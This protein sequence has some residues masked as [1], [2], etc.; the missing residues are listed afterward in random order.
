MVTWLFETKIE[1][2]ARIVSSK[3][4][5][6]FSWAI[7]R[8]EAYLPQSI[9]IT[10]TI[11]NSIETSYVSKHDKVRARSKYVHDF[12]RFP[13]FDVFLL[14]LLVCA[15]MKLSDLS[16]VYHPP[17]ISDEALG[18]L[19][20]NFQ[21]VYI[22]IVCI[23]FGYSFPLATP[24]FSGF[25]ACWTSDT[26]LA[27]MYNFFLGKRFLYLKSSTQQYLTLNSDV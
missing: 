3:R 25:W 14:R 8:C 19:E 2:E 24:F 7:D 5:F 9:F 15:I 4:L 16:A 17:Q 20:F 18:W 11:N 10:R 12:S 6:N 13:C 23:L 26:L 27:R 22:G 1:W 21:H